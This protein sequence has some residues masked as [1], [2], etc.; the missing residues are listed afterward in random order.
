MRFRKIDYMI[1]SVTA[2]IFYMCQL[3]DF[4]K[5]AVIG[6]LVISFIQALVLGTITNLL[7]RKKV[8]S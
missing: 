7:F 8:N 2:A 5:R 4:T 1:F 6:I 3:H